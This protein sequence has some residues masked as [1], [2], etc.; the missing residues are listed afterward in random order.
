MNITEFA[1]ITG[2]TVHTLR[3][4]EKVGIMSDVPRD[5]NGIRQ[6]NQAC[7]GKAALIRQLKASGMKLEDIAVYLETR[8]RG[9]KAQEKRKAVLMKTKQD[10]I[11]KAREIRDALQQIERQLA[12]QHLY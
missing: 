11:A 5:A 2:L 1:E 10:L 9:R 8:G 12:I 4:Y 7:L 3:Y 6:Y